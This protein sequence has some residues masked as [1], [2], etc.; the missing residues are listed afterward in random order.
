M[1]YLTLVPDGMA[2]RPLSALGGR[3]PMETARKPCM[4]RLA[5][6]STVGTVL[7]VPAGMVPESDTANM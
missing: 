7:H 1:K 2:D 5:R 3:T 4:D 6:M